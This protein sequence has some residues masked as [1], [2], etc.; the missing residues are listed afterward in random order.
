M[1]TIEINGVK[2]QGNF[3]V[4]YSKEEPV[5]V[6]HEFAPD[7]I[8]VL[9]HGDIGYAQF[10]KTFYQLES[11]YK[12]KELQV[13]SSSDALKNLEILEKLKDAPRSSG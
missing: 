5:C 11:K 1:L 8:L 4:V 13:A 7:S 6:V 10:L 2:H 9:R 12:A 3:I